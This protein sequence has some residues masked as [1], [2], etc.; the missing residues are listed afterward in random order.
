MTV[1]TISAHSTIHKLR[2]KGMNFRKIRSE[3]KAIIAVKT[4]RPVSN[5][6]TPFCTGTCCSV[7]K[8]ISIAN[9]RQPEVTI[10]NGVNL[11]AKFF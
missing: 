4:Q 6:L 10:F 8:I 11:K 7:L 2:S 9:T 1:N 3:M 5:K